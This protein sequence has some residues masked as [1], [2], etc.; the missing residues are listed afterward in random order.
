MPSPSHLGTDCGRGCMTC[1]LRAE[2]GAGPSC[3]ILRV[4]DAMKDMQTHLK[5][6]RTDAAECETASQHSTDR[7]ERELFAKLAAHLT[8]LANEVERVLTAT[9]H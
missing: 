3:S 9:R 8:V 5:K 2:P 7:T 6:L 1:P 4:G